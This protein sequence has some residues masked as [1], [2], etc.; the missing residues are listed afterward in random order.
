MPGFGYRREWPVLLGSGHSPAIIVLL[1]LFV[2]LAAARFGAW[3]AGSNKSVTVGIRLPGD[4]LEDSQHLGPFFQ[5]T[6]G[7]V[8][9]RHRLPN[10]VFTGGDQSSKPWPLAR[11]PS[12]GS[13]WR[14]WAGPARRR[15]APAIASWWISAAILD[16]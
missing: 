13:P 9:V 5:M 16:W 2:V 8:R 7:E 6:D 12:P 4:I 3:A 15:S 10:Q 14:C 1:L 11:W